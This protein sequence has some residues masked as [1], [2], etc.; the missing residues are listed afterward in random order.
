MKN[1]ILV[2][3]VALIA[4]FAS[5]KQ[6]VD[7]KPGVEHHVIVK[8][9]F[10]QTVSD[11]VITVQRTLS[12]S[13][14]QAACDAYNAV[15]IDDFRRV[16]IDQAPPIEQSPTVTVFV[17]NP[18]TNNPNTVW[19]NIPRIELVNNFQAWK[20]AF[21]G[22]LIYIDHYPPPPILDK[23]VNPYAWYALYIVDNDT[24]EILYED[25]CGFWA[26]QH[27]DSE[28]RIDRNGVEQYFSVRLDSF[29]IAVR[30]PT[31]DINGV[32][33]KS[34]RVIVRQIYIVPSNLP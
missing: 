13:D 27:F 10:W 3:C 24:G 11:T 21:P 9:A 2:L 5:C 12:I 4:G 1:F 18:E 7:T 15:T 29:N 32:Y 23:D 20:E 14:I 28:G 31:Q 22:Q 16:Y 26:D 25:H 19:E 17:C 33:H 30:G 8:N 6:P 34:C